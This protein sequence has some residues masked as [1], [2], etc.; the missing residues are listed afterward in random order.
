[1]F[2]YIPDWLRDRLLA[3][4]KERGRQPFRI[5]T[6]ARLSSA[7]DISRQRLMQVFELADVGEECATPHRF[8]HTFA[9]IP[10]EKGPNGYLAAECEFASRRTPGLNKSCGWESVMQI[11]LVVS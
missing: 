10:L 1:M 7:I 2:A 4:A 3:R 6:T 8:P 9:R 11:P 5:S